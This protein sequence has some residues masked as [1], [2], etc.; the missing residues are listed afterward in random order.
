MDATFAHEVL[1]DVRAVR[2]RVRGDRRTTSVPLLVFGTIT[3]VEALLRPFIHPIVYDIVALVLVPAGFAGI[4]LYYQGHERAIGVGSPTQSYAL[5]GL[6]LGLL[7]IV[8]FGIVL[9]FGAFAVVGFGLLFIAY[10]QRNLYLA[11]WAVIYG[12]VGT[13]EGLSLVS[14]RLYSIAQDLGLYRTTQGCFSWSTSLVYGVLGAMVIGA[15]LLARRKEI[16]TK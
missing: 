13:L 16:A 9:L 14:N 12:V 8:M 5:T 11:L 10:R 6:V 2:H 15:G 3:V 4:A 7:M 1:G